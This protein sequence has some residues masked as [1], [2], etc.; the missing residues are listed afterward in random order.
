[1]HTPSLPTVGALKTEV[2]RKNGK[3]AGPLFDEMMADC[4]E[5]IANL[6]PVVDDPPDPVLTSRPQLE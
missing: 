6:G 5:R 2:E 3:S 4:R 1:M